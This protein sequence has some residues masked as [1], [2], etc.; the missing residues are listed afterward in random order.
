MK[1]IIR[2][3]L[4][5][6]FALLILTF[7]V[8]VAGI[9]SGL[10]MKTEMFPDISIPVVSVSSN[11]PGA[12]PDE[13]MEKVT[14]PIEQRTR[15]LPGVTIVSSSSMDNASQ[16]T[17]QYD[18]AKDMT[19]AEEEVQKEIANMQFPEGVQ[20]PN[21]SRININAF[22]ILTL[23]MT[24]TDRSLDDLTK[25]A[26]E[27]I[28][29]QLEGLEG[30]SSVQISGQNYQEVAL[31]Y[32][33][34][35]LMSLG[36]NPDKIQDII[37]GSAFSQSLGLFDFDDS[38]KSLVFDGNIVTLDDLKDL[39]IPV[40]E[41]KD[42]TI[43]LKD[44]AD[45]KVVEKSESLSRT[46]GEDSIGLGIVKAPDAN[47]VEVV[48]NVKEEMKQFE[49]QNPGLSITTIMDQGEPI[50]KSVDSMLNKVL[51]GGIFAIII[52]LLF[53]RNIRSTLIAV[54][55]IPLSL[56]IALFLLRQ[57]GISLNLMTLG[58]MTIAIGRVVDDSIIVIENIHRRL[59]LSTEKLTG[60]ELIVSATKEMFV[61]ILSS[62][63]VSIAIFLPL[64]LVEGAI[65][66]MLLPFALTIVFALVASLVVAVTIVPMMGHK[67]MDRK[68]IRTV[69]KNRHGKLASVYKRILNWSLDHKL[70]TFG[71]A[72]VLFVASLFL[73]PIIG[74]S[75]L[76]D[77][78]E[79]EITL[80]YSATVD[81]SRS[82]VENLAMKAEKEILSLDDVETLQFS[83]GGQ[84]P[85]QPGNDKQAIFYIK[86][87]ED[88]NDFNQEKEALTGL[89]DG[90]GGQGEWKGQNTG[91]GSLGETQMELLVYGSDMQELVPVASDIMDLME[92][93]KDLNN[94]QSS[95]SDT[96]DQYRIIADPDSL[97]QYGLS[98]RQ[99]A[100]ELMP[101][102]QRSALTTIQQD[103][104]ELDVYVKENSE[105]FKN[106]SE[107]ENVKLLSPMKQDIDLKDVATIEEEQTPNTI[108]RRDDR[109]YASIKADIKGNDV[110]EISADLEKSVDHLDL[111]SSVEVSFG[112]V[113]RQMDDTFAQMGMAMLAAIGIV[114][115][116]LV[117]TFGGALAPFAV[118]F[119]LPFAVIGGLVGLFVAGEPLSLTALIGALMLI[120]IVVTNAIVLIDRTIHNQKEG[121]SIREAL[122]EA[123]GTRLRP[124]LMTAFSTMGALIPLAFGME[125]DGLVSRGMGITVIG[126]LASS[127]V[128]T[129]VIVP[130]V[131]EFLMGLKRSKKKSQ[132][133]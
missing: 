83:V 68:N 62:T 24:D 118:L 113:T 79:N 54:V 98:A 99:V 59:T 111:P 19:E 50:E 114:Y 8:T 85:M 6:K 96:F 95:I 29:S 132:V 126:G 21:V 77:Q 60:K 23:S 75:F 57:T 87:S 86:Y 39:P 107:L 11:Y 76:P 10:N 78:A 18:F 112:G 48:N 106:K 109:I 133:E 127:T 115:L 7:I 102:R 101:N 129:L 73:I 4:N 100:M 97:H 58:A 40:M 15:H 9:Y 28:I 65:G 49:K 80:T 25:L 90:L 128:L 46:N 5:N 51:V 56:L 125:S 72:V 71:G 91:G 103:G 64:G 55:S 117:L 92:K 130:V 35:K 119:S 1:R 47:I 53:L 110:K 124:I 74:F 36:L 52:I 20:A 2:F 61:P 122:V 116:A 37:Q 81:E 31:T 14:K 82:D 66:E 42:S 41:Q 84:N 16:V 123:G 44:I 34:D 26:E 43:T 94:V 105:M 120:G 27:Q 12:A 45:L 38:E 13:V 69:P 108:T 89:L 131:Y 63:V 70:V 93:N 67:M 3:S 22:P 104:N 32:D 30:V 121:L 17:I 33:T 88:V